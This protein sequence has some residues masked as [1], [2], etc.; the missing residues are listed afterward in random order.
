MKPNLFA[1]V[2]TATEHN[3][4]RNKLSLQAKIFSGVTHLR[5]TH[6]LLSVSSRRFKKRREVVMVCIEGAGGRGHTFA[7]I[8]LINIVHGLLRDEIG[9]RTYTISSLSAG[10]KQ[11]FS[12]IQH[13]LKK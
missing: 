1:T 9:A 11:C 13:L 4:Q 10:L 2:S 6:F 3:A 12:N 8:L 7:D 5:K